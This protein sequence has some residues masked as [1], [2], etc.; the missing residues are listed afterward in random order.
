[1]VKSQAY[2]HGAIKISQSLKS[3]IDALAV[4]SID[5]ALELRANKIHTR[6]VLWGGFLNKQEL[7]VIV[8]H[9]I[10]TL[11]YNFEQI[12]IL[13]HSTLIKPVKIWL[14]IDTGMHR[15]GFQAHEIVAA[16]NY[17]KKIKSVAKPLHYMTHFSDA[18]IITSPK[19]LHQIADFKK[20][21]TDWEGEKGFANSAAIL[22]WS[23]SYCEW[24]RPGIILYGISPINEVS[25]QELGF[26][27]V[28]TL[29]SKIVAIKTI[30]K[31]E[32]VSYDSTWVAPKDTRIGIVAI[33]YGDGY[34]QH[35]RSDTK[36]LINNTYCTIVGKVCMDYIAIDL[37]NS[38]DSKVGDQVILWGRGLPV[39]D[40]AKQA[41][42]S[43]YELCCQLTRRVIFEYQ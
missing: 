12:D 42:T 14:K 15:L 19:T 2:G 26:T 10:E 11:I 27:P 16:N 6:I 21:T 43:P 33:G 34:P 30:S 39:E 3:Q 9:D 18:S 5:E 29:A 24:I 37:T 41:G 22:H 31:G 4:A 1:M 23:D 7:Q 28:M 13:E 32:A 20:L 38:P 25:G 8:N 36:V 40:I 35:I 17:L